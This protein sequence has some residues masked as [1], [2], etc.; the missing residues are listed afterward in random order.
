M[1]KMDL[2]VDLSIL[3][4]E[5]SS[6]EHFSLFSLFRAT[7]VKNPTK[8]AVIYD[9]D[10]ETKKLSYE[11]LDSISDRIAEVLKSYCN[12]HMSKN[13]I[14]A[15]SVKPSERLPIILLSIL[16][17]GMAYLPIDVEFPA[18]RIRYILEDAQPLLCITEKSVDSRYFSNI[19]TVLD[20][21]LFLESEKRVGNITIDED[22]SKVA[23]VLYT[24]GS[25][26]TPKGVRLQYKALI[27]RLTWQ[28]E[29]LPYKHNENCCIFKT[30]ITFVDSVCEIW[31]PLMQGLTL[32][33]IPRHITK[34]PE[35]FIH[36]LDKYKIQRIVL[37]P[38]LLKSML[39]Y[40]RLQQIRSHLKELKLWICSGETLSVSLVQEFFH[41]FNGDNKLLANFYGSTEVMGDVTF[42]ILR[43]DNYHQYNDKIPIGRPMKNCLTY[44]VDENCCLI[45]QGKV[46]QLLIAGR[47]LA[48]GYIH[49]FNSNKFIDNPYSKDKDY[50]KVFCTGDYAKI[51][52][53]LLYYEGRYDNQVKIRGH[54]VDLSEVEKALLNLN[55]IKDAAV[56]STKPCDTEKLLLGFI[57]PERTESMID[58]NQIKT[59]LNKTLMPY[60]IPEIII[61]D[62]MPLL[63]NGK[64][65]RQHLLESYYKQQERSAI[66]NKVY[67][68][69]N[70]PIEELNKAKALFDTI[71]SVVGHN[72]CNIINIDANFY[73]IGGNSLNSIYT[74]LKLREQGF[75]IGITD[76]ITAK[77]MRDIVSKMT[78]ADM[79][80]NED[81]LMNTEKYILEMLKECHK[82]QV[83]EMI[84][85]S[86]FTKADLERWLIPDVKKEH[87]FDL[88]QILWDSLVEK[89]LSFVLKSSD[90]IILSV[91]LNFD[92]RDEPEIVIESKLSI[93][94]DFL[95]YLEKPI[96][97]TRLPRGK[98]TIFHTFMM[99]TKNDLDASENIILMRMMEQKCLEIAKS[100]NFL[101]ILTTNTSPL[102]QQLGTDIFNYEVMLDYQVNQYVAPDGTKPFQKAPNDQ[103]AVV[104]WIKINYH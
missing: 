60:M 45:S 79:N 32:I 16:K 90:N 91:S 6:S 74:I 68:Y 92:A 7:V 75:H 76:F 5:I 67:N 101:G 34:N 9:D 20:T 38:S 8:I 71:G 33:V 49:D 96:R 44:I 28:W 89:N 83:I 98:N 73:E 59:S 30:A 85:E 62:N 54:R 78:I 93:V 26:G 29:E 100:K 102:T 19:L 72:S 94:F 61:I 65:N 81:D 97:E 10:E 41:I 25:T 51:E 58:I 53:D 56:L 84:T 95:E 23:L 11:S 50:T 27:N 57:I 70:I 99:A 80:P 2:S 64:I 103:R 24:S 77:T 15:V 1:N 88:M 48:D 40:I 17:A 37:V 39:M 18:D 12:R 36:V 104:S 87:Y 3:K 52:N 43:E 66:K 21:D 42:Y 82:T 13:L 47:N 35:E 22:T 46:G 69:A 4:G 14:I 31:G 63:I 86:F 55:S